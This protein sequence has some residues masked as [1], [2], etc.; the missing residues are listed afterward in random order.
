MNC[1]SIKCTSTCRALVDRHFVSAGTKHICQ[2]R[3]TRTDWLLW[4]H[5]FF[6]DGAEI[7][8]Q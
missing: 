4:Y 8:C 5:F 1:Y 3:S 7:C 2:M 6:P